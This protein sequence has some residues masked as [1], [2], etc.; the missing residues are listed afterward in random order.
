MAL[1]GQRADFLPFPSLGR[2]GISN[3]PNLW[4]STVGSCV[5]A[6]KEETWVRITEVHFSVCFSSAD[7]E[8]NSPT[9]LYEASANKKVVFT[10]RILNEVSFRGSKGGLESACKIF[11]RSHSGTLKS[12]G[13]Y[14]FLK[15]LRTLVRTLHFVRSI[16]P[17]FITWLMADL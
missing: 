15:F 14:E 8:C 1:T 16:M 3:G 13:E 2:A 12:A 7:I 9:L 5:L 6:K 17:R 11:R 4:S 10:E